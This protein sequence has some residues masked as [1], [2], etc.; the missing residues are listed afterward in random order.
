MFVATRSLTYNAPWL[1]L[2]ADFTQTVSKPT[3]F[4]INHP[5]GVIVE[6][7]ARGQFA[8]ERF[9]GEFEFEA[10]SLAGRYGRI[11]WAAYGAAHGGVARHR[12]RRD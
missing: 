5:L 7:S 6:R 11:D 1:S 8:P 9:Q 3:A 2:P 10:A 12:G 4:A